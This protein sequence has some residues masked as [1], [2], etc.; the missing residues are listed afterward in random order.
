MQV[1]GELYMNNAIFKTS[2]WS[3]FPRED[4]FAVFYYLIVVLR[5]SHADTCFHPQTRL[6]TKVFS[7]QAKYDSSVYG[8]N[9]IK[10]KSRTSDTKI[11]NG[12]AYTRQFHVFNSV[13]GTLALVALSDSLT[14]MHNSRA[15]N[16]SSASSWRCLLL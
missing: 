6:Y 13:C 2:A 11:E 4:N 16:V 3:R 10:I 1:I 12:A 7:R 5:F 8:L 9:N 14:R 15:A